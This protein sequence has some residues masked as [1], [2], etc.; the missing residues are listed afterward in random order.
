MIIGSEFCNGATHRVNRWVFRSHV[1]SRAAALTGEQFVRRLILAVALSAIL[2][3][4]AGTSTPTPGGQP[5]S[6]STTG[7]AQSAA[8][9]IPTAATTVVPTSAPT[10]APTPT[11]PPT[12]APTATPVPTPT[13]TP[14]PPTPTAA[15][16]PTPAG[17]KTS[18]GDGTYRVGTDI[19]PGLYWT[20]GSNSCYFARLSGFTGSLDEIIAN[21]NPS[22]QAIV[23]VDSGDTGFQ[24]KRCGQ[25]QNI[26][27]L[28]VRSDP[29][30][31]FSDGTFKVGD[32]V[33][34]GTWKNDK[35][36]FCYW[37]R[38]SGF[39]AILDDVLA[40]GVEDAPTIVTIQTGD[41]GFTSRRCG[42]W[43]YVS[44]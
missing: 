38:L 34:P 21:D 39:G 9:V 26:T 33:A 4:C 6:V 19:A 5:T 36:S 32:Q 42:T 7:A 23:L 2:A 18:F 12:P 31:P 14:V 10:P 15:P 11:P 1:W 29:T 22:G 37:A 3:A 17:P 40:N 35:G 20:A 28:P 25:W 44:P 13:P 41:Q 43:T 27:S 16:T 30:A 8:T 24:S